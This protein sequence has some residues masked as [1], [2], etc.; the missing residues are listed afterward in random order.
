MLAAVLAVGIAFPFILANDA[1]NLQLAGDALA[2]GT[3]VMGL[4][5]LVGFTGLVSFGHA[6]WLATGAYAFG[7]LAPRLGRGP[8]IAATIA[9]TAMIAVPLGFVATRT[10]GLAF[11]IITLAE[12]VVLYT[13]ILHLNFLGGGIGLFGVPLPKIA[14]FGVLGSERSLYLFAL[15]LT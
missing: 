8:A 6:A 1:Y 12:G 15:A 4:D 11:A 13:I 7:Y 9:I 10:S 5:L 3:W 14:G 2:M